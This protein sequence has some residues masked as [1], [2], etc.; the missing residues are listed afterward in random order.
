MSLFDY[1]CKECGHKEEDVIENYTP[2]PKPRVCTACGKESA[3][4]VDFYQTWFALQGTGWSYGP[5]NCNNF[6]LI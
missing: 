5:S 2:E 6:K 3:I 1:K 4:R